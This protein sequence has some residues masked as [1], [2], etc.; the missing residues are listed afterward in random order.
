MVVRS[1]AFAAF[2]FLIAAHGANA[3]CTAAEARGKEEHVLDRSALIE[4]RD[5]N[6]GRSIR[7]QVLAM[8]LAGLTT[9]PN[10]DR[11]RLCARYDELL[12]QSK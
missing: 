1:S 11:D 3:A 5:L 6:K 12:E 7:R 10:V 8:H 4:M 9:G 2:I